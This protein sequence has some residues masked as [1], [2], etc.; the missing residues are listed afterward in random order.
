MTEQL[1]SG[2]CTSSKD[3]KLLKPASLPTMSFG[4]S[5]GDLVAAVNTLAKIGKALKDSGGAATEYQEAVTY[6]NS[7]TRTLNGLEEL[8]QN[9]PN[10]RWETDLA[11][12]GNILR[13]VIEDF[14]KKIK[15]YDNSL[16]AET[17]RKKAR[18]V[19]REV[20]FALFLS[21]QVKELRTAITQPQLILDVFINLQTL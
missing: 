10:L 14:D 7:I 9:N 20:Q 2:I 3:R 12:Q 21:D 4:W 13:S 11:E 8:L 15:K 18:R 5:A 6:L 1:Q 16:G 19:P 17:E